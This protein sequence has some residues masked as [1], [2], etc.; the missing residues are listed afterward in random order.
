MKIRGKYP[1]KLQLLSHF[2]MKDE[3]RVFFSTDITNNNKNNRLNLEKQNWYSTRT[4]SLNHVLKHKK[5]SEK[6]ERKKKT[7][8]QV[9]ESRGRGVTQLA[10]TCVPPEQSFSAEFMINLSIQN[11]IPFLV[12]H[13]FPLKLT[14]IIEKGGLE[15]SRTLWGPPGCNAPSCLPYLVCGKRL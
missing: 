13:L 1:I 7:S 11:F 10:W 2:L 4:Q 3:V 9:R 8:N 14:S 6:Q 5:P 15:L 12:P